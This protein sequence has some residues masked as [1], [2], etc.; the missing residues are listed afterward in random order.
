MDN[1]SKFHLNR[2]VNEPENAVLG[3]LRKLKKMVAP[4]T[5]QSG[6][7]RLVVQSQRRAIP[8]PRK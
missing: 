6:T 4:I 3:K 2:T 1:L 8:T 5:Q 7:L